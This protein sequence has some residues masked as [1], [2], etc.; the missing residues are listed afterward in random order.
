MAAV[1][2]NIPVAHI[3][4]G[5]VSGSIDE[6]I[7]HAITKL[8]HLHFA[9]SDEAANRIQRMGED[10][11]SIFAVGST[12]L[13]VI[14][15]LDLCNL[16]PVR[17]YQHDAGAGAMIDLVRGEYL[18]LNQHPVTTEYAE[19]L[20]NIRE[21]IAAIEEL[22]LPTVWIMPNM[23]AGSDGIN[24]GIRQFRETSNP[25]YV[26]FFK[27]LPIELYAPL[28]ANAACMLGNSS[29]GIRES[30]FLGTPTVNI[31]SRQCGRQRAANVVDVGYDRRAI[32]D[33]VRRQIAHGQYPAD[34]LYGDGFASEKI[35]QTLRTHRV[36]IQKTLTY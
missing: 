35:V 26:H 27:S 8:A 11:A 25:E 30:A 23:D 14:R 12:S 20:A 28:L 22:R 24:E 3:E 9:A 16:D 10:P 17:R 34:H 36:R 1:Y 2:M 4:G 19:N 7:R 6:S 21:T 32:V 31:G 13:D 33:A 5:E 15:Q 29:S 18:V